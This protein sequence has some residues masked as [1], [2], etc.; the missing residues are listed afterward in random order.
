MILH[1][2]IFVHENSDY[3]KCVKHCFGGNRKYIFSLLRSSITEMSNHP[4]LGV[5]TPAELR[6]TA[7]CGSLHSI[8]RKFQQ[9]RGIWHTSSA[10]QPDLASG[11]G[12][13]PSQI[14]GVAVI[15]K[16]FE[17]LGLKP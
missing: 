6:A 4:S 12:P 3:E 1:R 13:G 10:Q 5:S 9:L 8:Q 2:H 11:Y 14:Q 7:L 15:T 16:V 17:S